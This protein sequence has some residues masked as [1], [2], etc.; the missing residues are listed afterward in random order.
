MQ[1][2]AVIFGD[3]GPDVR[4]VGN[5]EGHAG[6]TCWAT[7]T[8]RAPEEGKLPA[9]GFSK[10]EEATEGT[11]YGK[12][13]LPAECDVPLRP[14]WFYHVSQDGQ[15]K[16]PH[17]LMDLYYKSVG[18][19]ACL[20]LG[21]SP[22]KRGLIPEY[23][24]RV[25]KEFGDLLRQTFKVNL[26]KGATFT[27]SNIRGG[28][29]AKFG[30]SFLLDNDR[31]SYWAT[32]DS[33]T[34]PELI[35]TLPAVR[36]FNIIR[37]RENIKLGQRIEGV[38]VD[39]FLQ[40]AWKEIGRVTSIGANRLIRLP[41]DVST[42]KLRV[43]VTS[44]PVC[45]TLSDFALFREPVQLPVPVVQRDKSGIVTITGN[46]SGSIHYTLDGSRPSGTSPVYTRPFSL[47][48]GGTV[49]AVLLGNKAEFSEI[50]TEIYGFSKKNWKVLETRPTG[51]TG[52]TDKMIDENK[53]SFWNSLT[54]GDT[55]VP[56]FPR[57]VVIDMGTTHT[58]RAF[59][60]LPRQDKKQEGIVNSYRF[61]VSKDNRTWEVAAEGEFANIA[62][63]PLEQAVL[64]EHPAE[65]IRYIKFLAKQVIG[66][67]GM[68]V[69]ELGCR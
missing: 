42:S 50:I 29:P 19:G 58:I 21:L 43:S 40:G 34:R 28:N 33:V 30:P 62:A 15:A 67:R 61:M 45:I 55:S 16:S 35:I 47:A 57:E 53:E 31:Y 14:G 37:L 26:A 56:V 6:E 52:N 44:S 11:R 69:A 38:V 10:Y 20:D 27:A 64:L 23:D 65:G 46:T 22:D 2:G 54:D 12:Y 59:T 32:D 1:P 36:T 7:Y 13:W 68:T 24:C 9:N 51:V 41:Q 48:A 17:Q 3:I 66:N 39:A 8:P 60:Y 18:R 49:K 25:L 5:E 4:W 63:N